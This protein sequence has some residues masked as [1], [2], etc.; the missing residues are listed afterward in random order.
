[1]MIG[2]RWGLWCYAPAVLLLVTV[3]VAA[4]VTGTAPS[5]FTRD[6]AVLLDAFP[7]LGVVSYVG[8]LVWAATAA[9][10]WFTS[11]VLRTRQAEQAPRRFLFFAGLLTFWLLLDDLF[12]F[13]EWLFPEVLGVR[14]RLLFAAY[15]GLTALFL[16]RFRAL[17]LR[18][19]YALL[20]LALTFFATSVGFDVLP[21]S[22]FR[23]DYL[24]LIEDSAKLFGIVSWFA[25]FVSVCA[26]TLAEQEPRAR[27]AGIEP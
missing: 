8:I 19:N 20:V 1:M 10:T 7:L 23:W 14:Q 4:R 13:H 24:Y 2:L 9:I 6:P 17:I 3:A 27:T 5:Q 18:S 11:A 22:A 21:E 12:L 26:V 25:Y 15:I 16:V